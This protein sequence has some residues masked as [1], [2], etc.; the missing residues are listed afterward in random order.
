MMYEVRVS[1]YVS[2]S[3]FDLLTLGLL[4]LIVIYDYRL[5]DDQLLAACG[6]RTAHK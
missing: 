3:H 5:T 4:L 2:L 1:V 6:G